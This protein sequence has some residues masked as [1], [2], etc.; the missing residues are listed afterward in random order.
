MN[1]VNPRDVV[2]R[3]IE[4]DRLALARAI[5]VVEDGL[6]PSREII[7]GVYP[8]TG[9]AYIVGITGSPGVGKS[10]LTDWLIGESRREG[11]KVGVIAVDPTS[12]FSG[13]AILGDR[14]RMASH[15]LDRGVFIRS[16]ATRGHLGG[17]SPAT[18]GVITLL[19]AYGCDVIFLETVGAGQSEI[20]VMKY[21][22]TVVV[23]LAPGMGDDVQAMKAGIMEIGD[24]FAVNKSDRE[25]ADG[26]ALE[27]E[28]MLDLAGRTGPWR[29][30]V[31]KTVATTGRG[32]AELAA[33]IEEHAAFVRGSGGIERHAARVA[34]TEITEVLKERV[35]GSIL[36]DSRSDGR[37]HNV[38]T[39][40][41][42]RAMDPYEAAEL[43][44]GKEPEGV[45]R[46]GRGDTR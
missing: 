33:R 15:A 12:P 21:A 17:L 5:T 22:H 30:P 4:G 45:E 39:A 18:G 42:G 9:R 26:T 24:V 27:I 7:R 20:E 46:D 36:R 25:G 11:K 1:A 10:T 3:I 43:L 16:L 32:I 38:V 31:V 29:P 8:H 35:I 23:V 44:L 14:L 37:W 41:A 2:A 28:Y 34:E 6:P 19:D 13:G 40:V